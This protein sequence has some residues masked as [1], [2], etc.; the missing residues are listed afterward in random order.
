MER[1]GGGYLQHQLVCDPDWMLNDLSNPGI[2]LPISN[3]IPSQAI[4]FIMYN[5]NHASFLC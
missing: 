2:A 1:G 4:R 5:G 3:N